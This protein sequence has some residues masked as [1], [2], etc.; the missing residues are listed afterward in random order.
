MHLSQRGTDASV[1]AYQLASHRACANDD[2]RCRTHLPLDG[3]IGAV[4]CEG[5][6]LSGANGARDTLMACDA[7]LHW[8]M[9]DDVSVAQCS[10]RGTQLTGR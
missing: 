9:V 5:L 4:H 1:H 7:G 2:C 10:S 6:R 8:R 3:A